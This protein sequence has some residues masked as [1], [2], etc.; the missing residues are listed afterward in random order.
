MPPRFVPGEGPVPCSVLYCGEGPGVNED[1]LGRPFVGRAGDVLWQ[2]SERH[3]GLSRGEVY[4][5]NLV[6][7]RVPEDGD[8]S[9][10]D[11]RRDAPILL[12][13]IERVK[14]KLIVALGRHSFR[15]L[16]G[17]TEAAMEMVNGLAFTP[18]VGSDLEF[19]LRMKNIEWLPKVLAVTHP[20][21]GLRSPDLLKAT[22]VGMRAIPKALAGDPVDWKPDERRAHY[23]E[24]T[25]QYLRQVLARY[26]DTRPVFVDTEG[27]KSDPWCLTFSTMPGVAYLIRAGQHQR[28]KVFADWLVKSG[29]TVVL[30]NALHD[31]AVLRALGVDLVALGVPVM[32][33][34][35]LAFVRGTGMQGLKNLAWREAG[36]EM[37]EY[38]EVIGPHAEK[39][40][41]TY[42]QQVVKRRYAWP[43]AEGR[44]QP[45]WKRAAGILK[46][47]AA[48]KRK[49][50]AAWGDLDPGLRAPVERK[51]GAMPDLTRDEALAIPEFRAY[52]CRDADATNRILG[53]L[54]R[55]V[56]RLKLWDTVEL[57]M[58]V[59]P[60]LDRMQQTG[61]RL[62]YAAARVL[63]TELG[64]EMETARAVADRYAVKA[65]LVLGK[66]KGRAK[67]K[68]FVR[69]PFNPASA[70]QTAKLLFDVLG[71]RPKDGS[72]LRLTKSKKRAQ[73]DDRILE[74]FSDEHPVIGQITDY[75]ELQKTKGTFVDPLTEFLTA[76]GR[77]LPR[78]RAT[79]VVS[80]R[81]ST[82]DPN[83]LA[84]PTRTAL[85]KR[86]RKLFLPPNSATHDEWLLSVDYSQI[87]LRVMAE[88]SGDPTLVA[89][90]QEGSKIDL[91]R[92]TA[93]EV[94]FQIP[95]DQVTESQR[96]FGKT[97]NFAILYGIGAEALQRQFALS[98]IFKTVA[99]CQAI[100]N[101][102][103]A[104]F[105]GVST[106]MEKVWDQTERDGYVRT[107]MLGR[108]RWLP[109]IHLEGSGWP[110]EMIREEAKRQA[111]NLCIQGDAGTVMKQGMVAVWAAKVAGT[112][113][114]KFKAT[115]EPVLQI[116]DDLLGAVRPA[117]KSAR[118]S[119]QQM[120]DVEG[121]VSELLVQWPREQGWKV[122]VKTEAKWG[123]NWGSLK[124]LADCE[125]GKGRAA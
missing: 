5:T 64:E 76:D 99:E 50:R 105:R 89:A 8:P 77:I 68:V 30:H 115:W 4:V 9:A 108:I 103:M 34:M 33:T 112:F 39:K 111:V 23:L 124:K 26:R 48:G 32:D 119:R 57:D 58:A 40:A 65:G 44:A 11:I 86:V 62:D 10:A 47:V 122:P 43:P 60:M 54:R 72:P 56:T 125:L 97:M 3:A 55:D 70:D 25:M 13:E 90:F 18:V 21:A 27:S 106:F 46:S 1:R 61:F 118:L 2:M 94:I 67:A 15:F 88:L 31:L 29:H 6:K 82:S 7:Y 63:S 49:A 22:M 123:R 92:L 66:M 79:R 95:E 93:A 100:I 98:G 84:F 107:P 74:G 12:G 45:V 117:A 51:L 35:E 24:P 75:R 36:M 102:W 59:I 20:A 91:H 113:E 17:F 37:R 19:H 87:E 73:A 69:E 28:L 96:Y 41:V 42:L 80:G 14:P 121:Y 38:E 78:I 101:R 53:P 83:L 120:Q 110:F 71:L 85:G 16:T 114:K 109:G 52:A 81:L 104:R 116:H